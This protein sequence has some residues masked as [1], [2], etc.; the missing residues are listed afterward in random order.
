MTLTMGT[1]QTQP[2]NLL[3]NI[4]YGYVCCLELNHR[5]VELHRNLSGSLFLTALT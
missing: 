5:V 2:I 3:Y 4:A 1:L